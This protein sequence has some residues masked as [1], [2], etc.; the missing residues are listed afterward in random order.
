VARAILVVDDRVP[1]SSLG[2]GFGR[3]LDSSV[4]LPSQGYAVSIYPLL[5]VTRPPDQLVDAGVGVVE[6]E[7]ATHLSR[8]GVVYEAV[9]ISRPHNYARIAPTVHQLQPQA[10]VVYDCE[11]LFWRRM[12]R[13]ARLADSPEKAQA[14]EAQAAE[15]KRL[16]DR[17]AVEVDAIVTVSGEEAAIISEIEGHAPVH[18]ILPAE[19]RI[20]FTARPF[21]GRCDIGYVAGWQ[22]GPA[23][24][25][26]DGLFWFVREVLPKVKAAVPWV[27]VRVTGSKVPAELLALADPNVRFEGSGGPGVVL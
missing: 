4:E 18:T 25:N 1:E 11:A 6:G 15:M 7:L 17:I 19:P 23:S 14:I 10:L 20:P 3:M 12:V 22:A 26:A 5:G 8:P 24:P 21:G 16:E 13:Q 2:S 27:R 9:I